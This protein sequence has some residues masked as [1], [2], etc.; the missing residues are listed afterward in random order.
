MIIEWTPY[1][2]I[3]WVVM[4]VVLVELMEGVTAVGETDHIGDNHFILM[5]GTCEKH[6]C[7]PQLEVAL[8]AKVLPSHKR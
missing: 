5:E 3:S 6:L 2:V 8:Y 7:V 4:T 1:T